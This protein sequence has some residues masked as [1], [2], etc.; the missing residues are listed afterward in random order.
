MGIKRM[1]GPCRKSKK[2]WLNFLQATVR[3]NKHPLKPKK[4]QG[5]ITGGRGRGTQEG[6]GRVMV[7]YMYNFTIY[8]DII[9]IV[10]HGFCRIYSVSIK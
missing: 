8:F 3:P 4:G 10:W 6:G 2:F 1:K 9:C 7:V 5:G